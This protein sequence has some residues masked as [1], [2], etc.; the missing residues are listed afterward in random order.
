MASSSMVTSRP[1]VSR[2][3]KINEFVMVTAVDTA[4]GTECHIPI[5]AD[6]T[7]LIVNYPSERIFEEYGVMMENYA[8]K[9]N[10]AVKENGASLPAPGKTG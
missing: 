6:G 5:T 3:V 8:A 2:M 9:E 7:Y 4:G 10:D 1:W